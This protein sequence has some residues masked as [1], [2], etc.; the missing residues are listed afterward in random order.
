VNYEREFVPILRF[1]AMPF[2]AFMGFGLYGFIRDRRNGRSPGA[3]L[4]MIQAISIFAGLLIFSVSSRYR[5]PAVPALA[6]LAGFG[7]MQV[8]GDARTPRFRRLIVAAACVIPAFLISLARYP[9][10]PIMPSEPGNLGVTYMA[11][12]DMGNAVEYIG[13]ALEMNPRSSL[14][15]L[16]MGIALDRLGRP[17]EAM[18]HFRE[19]L[20]FSPRDERLLLSLAQDLVRSGRFAEAA[21]ECRKALEVNPNNVEARLTLG[22]AYSELGRTRDAI[23]ELWEVVRLR[24]DVAPAHFSLAIL[25]HKTGEYRAAWTETH[26]SESLG[27]QLPR[28]FIRDL[29]EKMPD[30]GD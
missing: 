5:T 15:H 14:A 18:D 28:S 13:Q 10:P 30:P 25:L 1:L 19:G 7:V 22:A 3:E 29:S 12:G 20:K 17:D 23:R 24:P 9:I 2:A 8:I 27:L 26:L 11:V 4:L 21:D 16:N 6:V